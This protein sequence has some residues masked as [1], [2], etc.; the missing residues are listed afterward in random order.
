MERRTKAPGSAPYIAAAGHEKELIVVSSSKITTGGVDGNVQAPTNPE[1]VDVTLKRGERT[2]SM[3][4]RLR[5]HSLGRQGCPGHQQHDENALPTRRM[6]F[7][8]S[9]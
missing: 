5:E 3:Q 4:V 8:S 7:V 6:S 2:C 9:R 1:M